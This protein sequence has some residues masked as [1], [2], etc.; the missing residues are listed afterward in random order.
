[1]LKIDRIHKTKHNAKRGMTALQGKQIKQQYT[2]EKATQLIKSRKE[3]GLWYADKDF[4]DDEDDP[5]L[6]IF[7]SSLL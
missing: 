3:S 5:F 1:M 4:P 7:R 2:A 6:R